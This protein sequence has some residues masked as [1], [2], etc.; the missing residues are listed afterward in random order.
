MKKLAIALVV[1]ILLVAA[2]AT[3]ALADNGPHGNF[4]ADTD[5]CASCHRAHTAQGV[6]YLLLQSD[7]YVLCTTCHDGSGAYTNVVDGVYENATLSLPAPYGTQGDKGQG[8]FGGGF[9]NA[10]MNTVRSRVNGYVAGTYP[11]PAAVNSHHDVETGTA[12]TVWGT[13]DINTANTATLVMECTS[14]HDPHGN[15]GAVFTGTSPSPTYRLLR[16]Q[17]EGSNGYEVV[18]GPSST[19]FTTAYTLT[20]TAGGVYVADVTTKWYTVNTDSTKDS[21]V[22]AFRHRPGTPW[23]SYINMPGDYAGRSYIYARPSVNIVAGTASGAASQWSC[24]PVA[25]GVALDTTCAYNGANGTFDNTAPMGKLGY[26]CATCH[27]RYL[28]T[29]NGRTTDSGDT[30]YKFRHSTTSVACVNCHTAHGS[31]AVMTTALAQ[32][33]TLNTAAGLTGYNNMLKLDNRALCADCHGYEVGYSTSG[34]VT[35]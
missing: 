7:I 12:G 14:C 8:L 16:F 19:Y 22:V 33:A 29:G 31:T 23:W 28:A 9:T 4:A 11:T 24:S 34:L 6:N 27:D 26:W 1:G 3:T 5:A 2:L 13:G 21:S 17:P 10:A 18:T 35:P 15:A 20:G 25:T 32:N 30:V